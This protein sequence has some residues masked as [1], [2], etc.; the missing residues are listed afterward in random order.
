MNDSI[1][2]PNDMEGCYNHPSAEDLDVGTVV[3]QSEQHPATL[4]YCLTST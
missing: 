1:Y 3:K 2:V 4:P